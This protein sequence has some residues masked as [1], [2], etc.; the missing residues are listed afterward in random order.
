M[1]RIVDLRAITSPDG[2]TPLELEQLHI[3]GKHYDGV[4]RAPELRFIELPVTPEN[5]PDGMGYDGGCLTLTGFLSLSRV[6][7]D[8]ALRFDLWCL[9]PDAASLFVAG[10]TEIVAGRC[11]SSWMTPDLRQSFADAAAL[12]A[13]MKAANIW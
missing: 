4:D 13:A 10:T 1:W 9:D 11:Q 7:V 5:D 12:D 3:A 2:L 6:Y 8:T